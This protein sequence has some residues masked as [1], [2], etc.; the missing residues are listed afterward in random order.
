MEFSDVAELQTLLEGV[1]LPAEREELLEY[2]AQ[3][4]ASATQLGMLKR[5]PDE[6]FGTIDEVGEELISVQPEPED[7]VPHEPK[8]ESGAPPGGDA[9]TQKHPESGAVRD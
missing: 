3:Q 7:E 4:G 5:L 1:V 2:A 9:Y 6:E 8:E